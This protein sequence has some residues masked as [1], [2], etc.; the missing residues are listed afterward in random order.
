MKKPRATMLVKDGLTLEVFDG[1]YPPSED[2]MLLLDCIVDYPSTALEVCCGTGLISLKLA[3]GGT[4]VIASDIDQRACRNTKYN[5]RMNRLDHMI[6]VVRSDMLASVKGEFDVIYSNPPYLP[7]TDKVPENIWWSSSHGQQNK[8]YSL[9]E[10]AKNNLK[11][12]GVLLF[13]LSSLSETSNVMRFLE[14]N[15]FSYSV[16]KVSRFEFEE[17]FVMKCSLTKRMTLDYREKCMDMS[18][19][20]SDSQD[21]YRY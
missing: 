4:K 6:D 12:C 14:K 7:F 2:T 15:N 8:I 13:V 11:I 20:L 21:L 16:S 5:A 3:K 10:G 18:E 1:V 9:I 19:K 17:I